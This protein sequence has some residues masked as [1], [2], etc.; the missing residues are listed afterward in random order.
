[1]NTFYNSIYCYFIVQGNN[2]NFILQVH[3]CNF[4]VQV[5]RC[6]FIVQ[7]NNKVYGTDI[8]NFSTVVN[9][10]YNSLFAK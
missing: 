5:S 6:N 7:V 8:G 10:K 1:M 4:I 9:E 2:C 3:K